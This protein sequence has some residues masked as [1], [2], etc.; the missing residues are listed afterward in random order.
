MKS[1]NILLC[2]AALAGLPV[3]CS[4]GKKSAA[5]ELIMA[6]EAT[7]PPYEYRD[8]DKIIGI[9]V[10]IVQEVADRLGCKLRIDDVK[11]D[12]VIPSVISGKCDIGASGI[13][14]TEDRKKQVNFTIP[15][16]EAAQV[17]VVPKG[18]DIQG[19]SDMKGKRIGVQQ[20]TT[21]D[22]YVTDNIQEPER[23]ENGVFAC[24]ALATGKLD[25]V[26]LDN[27][28]AKAHCRVHGNIEILPAPLTSESYAFA[29]SKK[30]QEL[31]E[32]INAVLT[33]MK[34]AGRIDEI[35]RKYIPAEE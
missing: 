35:I 5:G 34:S 16:I 7:F 21:G 6:T 2:A 4:C 31:L 24:T 8:G 32:K 23:F 11:F 18:S 1:L 17:I 9:D 29:V 19:E 10:E 22:H 26:V 12:S 30:N 13:T 28:P 3:L 27:E 14:V 20:G 33:D 25:V 15:Y